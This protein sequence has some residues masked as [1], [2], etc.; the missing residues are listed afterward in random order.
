[1]TA[2]LIEVSSKS[3]KYLSDMSQNP[4]KIP[5]SALLLGLAGTLPFMWGVISTWYPGVNAYVPDWLGPRFYGPYVQVAYGSII[6]S[7]MSGV[8]WGFATRAGERQALCY[9]LSVVP[10]LWVFFAVGGGNVSATY[11]LITGFVFLLTLDKLFSNWGLAPAWWMRLRLT[12]TI[13]VVSCLMLGL[14]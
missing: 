6:L 7:F 3:A 13:I 10:A 5:N 14:S 12:L 9:A 2:G 1:M 4:T 11:A 8:L